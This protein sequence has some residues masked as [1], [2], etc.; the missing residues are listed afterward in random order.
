MKT[1]RSEQT[2]KRVPRI[3]YVAVLNVLACFSVVALHC[4][5]M[6][7]WNYRPGRAW[8]FGNLVETL[9]YFAVPIFFM[10]SGVT[11]LEYRERYSTRVYLKKRFVKTVIP[12]LAWSVIA[13]IYWVLVQNQ[14]RWLQNPLEVLDGILNTRFVTI[15][16]F[17]LPL[18]AVYLA[19]PVLAR[20]EDKLQTFR[21]AIILGL[22]FVAALPLLCELIGLQ[23]NPAL[24]PPPVLGYVIY[25]L[26]GYNLSKV[27][28]S[29]RQRQ[30][31]YLCGVLGWALHFFGT[32]WLSV[33]AGEVVMTWKGYTNL[34][35]VMQ[36]IAVFVFFKHL[37]YDKWLKK[38]HKLKLEAVI[39]WLSSVT[40]GIYLVHIYFVLHVPS[41]LGFSE[42]NWVWLAAGAVAVFAV[43][44][45]IV[46]LLQKIPGVRRIIP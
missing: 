32:W 46:W 7:F 16:W 19:I 14:G 15:Y 43:C 4:S 30:M 12:F 11:L 20:V 1:K 27:T 9:F 5:N 8:L 39:N 36:A 22:I 26:L 17:F 25:V 29:K 40:F 34:P 45:G 10:L 41:W 3:F 24:T 28:L 38:L 23:Y 13:Y 6:A 42:D 2:V 33:R 21:Y 44:A 35:A 31:I 18:F 37:D